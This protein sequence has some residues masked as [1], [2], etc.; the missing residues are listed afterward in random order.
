MGGKKSTVSMI[1]TSG[2]TRYTAAS[3]LIF[4]PTSSSAGSRCVPRGRR[5]CA[6]GPGPSFAPQPAQDERLVSLISSRVNTR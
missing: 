5:T 6:S 3:S 2:A 4:R 1:A